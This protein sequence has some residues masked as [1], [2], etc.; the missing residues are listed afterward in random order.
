MFGGPA[1]TWDEAT[2]QCYY[3]AF[4]PQQPDLNWR[5]PRV[6]EAMY[7]VLRFWLDARRRRLPRSTP[8]ATSIKDDRWRDNPPN[9][10]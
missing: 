6:R 9:P 2:G 3:H 8:C 4:L 10:D 5:N 1:W 7:D